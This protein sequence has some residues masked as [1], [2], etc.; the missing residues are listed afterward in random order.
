[1]YDLGASVD[2]AD[3]DGVGIVL[4]RHKNLSDLYDP[5]GSH[6]S[7]FPAQS[8]PACL[9]GICFLESSRICLRLSDDDKRG[10]SSRQV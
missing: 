6:R 10:D 9:I 7:P 3:C 2:G 4:Y 5:V 8:A 1:M